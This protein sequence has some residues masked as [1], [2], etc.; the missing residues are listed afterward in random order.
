GGES[1]HKKA[2]N[3]HMQG[4]IKNAEIIYREAIRTGYLN[5]SLFSNLG[6]ICKNSGRPEEAIA[7]YKKAIEINPNAPAPPTNLGNLYRELGN[8]D[9]ALAS[10]LKSLK[11]KP[12]N[13][14]AYHNLGVIYKD[15]GNLDQALASTLKSLELKPNN[16]GAFHHLNV[17]I[18]EITLSASNALNLTKAY[19]LMLNLKNIFHGKLSAI[20]IHLF[21]PTIQAV[22]KS[23]LIISE[24]SDALNNLA[25]DWRLRKSLTLFVPPHQ[26]FEHFLT[27]LRKELLTLASH[28]ETI[29]PQLRQLSEALATQCFLNEYVYAQSP[30]EEKLVERLIKDLNRHQEEFNQHLSIIACYTPIYKLNLNQELL[31]HYPRATEESKT[32]IQIQLEEPKEEESIKISIQSNLTIDDAVSSIVKEMYEENPYPQ[33]RY[34]DHTD[35][36]LAKNPSEAIKLEST[37]CNLQFSD[38]LI[39]NHSHPKVLIA[40]CGTGNQVINASRYKNAEIT[41]IDLSRASLAYAIRKAKEYELKNISFKMLDILEA[42]NL[43]E[44]FDIIECSG[45]LHH[46]E[47]PGK[48]LSALNSQ[49]APGGYIKLGLYSEIA[50]QQIIAARN[51]INQLDFKSTTAGIRDFRN[52]VLLGELNNLSDLPQFGLDFYSLS[53]CRDLCFHVQEHRFTTAELQKLLDSQG[54]I[55]CGFLPLGKLRKTYQKQYPEDVDMT[56][57]KNWGEF[58]KQ[59]PS[60]F[61]GMYQFWAYKPS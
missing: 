55:F 52:K 19:E 45:V 18:S 12:N 10:T 43:D 48:G 16:P 6:V 60:T 41:A 2:V 46:M 4:D 57:L 30:E 34:A 7:L 17:V 38:E 27:R 28:Q 5:H 39:A 3:L 11:L 23:S 49:L 29:P 47:D 24:D 61:T 58:E 15:L 33:Y 36:S 51:Q 26:D 21:L 25:A 8:L 32:L 1:L 40:G 31:K 37:K 42:G 20:L 14:D 53:A 56:S 13:P 35:K 44:T 59:H 50:R 22:S 54:L 9:Q